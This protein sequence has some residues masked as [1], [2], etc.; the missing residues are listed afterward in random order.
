MTN[1]AGIFWR[2]GGSNKIRF[3]ELWL[4]IA[5]LAVCLTHWLSAQEAHRS[6]TAQKGDGIYRLLDR[7]GL[8]KEDAPEFIRLNRDDLGLRT[9]FSSDGNTCCPIPKA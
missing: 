3:K 4:H 9:R 8:S 6:V 2:K 7:H 5:M 1:Q